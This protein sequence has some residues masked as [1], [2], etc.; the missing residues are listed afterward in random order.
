MEKYIKFLREVIT[1]QHD[2]TTLI[3]RYAQG[4]SKWAAMKVK[5]PNVP[6]TIV[7]LSVAD[8]ELKNAPE[9]VQGLQAYI[10]ET[11]LGYTATSDVY[12]QAL[13]DWMQRRHNWKVEKDW[14]LFSA[15]VVSGVGAAVQAYTKPGDGVIV[16]QPV[17]YPFKMQVELNNRI[18]VNNPL[19]LVG[20]RYEMDFVDLEAKAKEPANTAIILCSPH[21]PVGRVWTKEELTKLARICIDNNVMIISDEIHFDLIKPG[22][23]HIVFTTISEEAAQHCIVLTA[24]SK[25]FN[26]AGLQTSNVIIPNKELREQYAKYTSRGINMLGKKACELA[27]NYAEGW[28]DECIALIFH[29]AE[30]VENFLAAKMPMIKVTP[31]EGT[32]LMWL[33]FKAFGL[34]NQALEDFM[35]HDALWFTDEGYIFGDDGSGYERINI[36][37]PTFVIEE[38]LDRLYKA[39]KAKKLI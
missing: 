38:A 7:P 5:N 4:S 9:I 31:M 32:Y 12:Y 19:K 30:L 39:A 37:C 21:N 13:I 20:E 18:M 16:Q 29:N 15:G 3:N 25:T 23:K 34:D 14:I 6:D 28:L 24:P 17:Y 11:I 35:V 36:A 10:G 33:N 1:M 22:M 2:F 26:L 27:Y 8:M